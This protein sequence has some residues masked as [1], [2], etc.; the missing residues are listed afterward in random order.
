VPART[1]R[2]I[3]TRLYGVM[4]KTMEDP[5]VVKRLA[6]GGADVVTSRSQEEF[7]AFLKN[8]TAFWAKIVKDVGATAE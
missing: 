2:P 3:V 6:S 8:Q 7:A 5:E 1:P 4:I